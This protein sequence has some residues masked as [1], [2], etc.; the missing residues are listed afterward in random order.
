MIT[1]RSCILLLGVLAAGLGNGASADSPAKP[2]IVHFI[3]D[4]LGYYE[5]SCM[6]HPD[7]RTPN[8][9]KLAGDGIRFTQMLA[10][11]SVCAPTRC[12]LMTGKHMGHA[13]VRG[14]DGS[15]PLLPGEETIAT[16]LKRAGYA[17]GGFGKWGIGARGT[18]GVPEQHGFDVFF[19][20][21]DQTHAHTYYPRYLIRNS[22]EVP[23]PGNTGDPKVGQT[24]SQYPIFNESKAFIRANKDRPFYLYLPWTPPH[25]HWGMPEDDPSFALYKDRAWPEDGRIYAAMVHMVD[26]QLGE[27]RALLDEL[28]LADNTLILFTGD[29]GGSPYFKTKEHAQGLFGP[30]VDPKTGTAFRG[31]KRSLYEGGLRVAAIACWPGHIQPGRVSNHPCYFPD[32]LPTF[33]ELVEAKAPEGIDGI[34]LLPEL[35]GREQPQHRYL[36]WELGTQTAIRM[37]QWKAYRGS[38]KQPWELYDLSSDISEA[39]NVA[40][41]NP[42]LLD[43]MMTF[44]AEARTPPVS[45]EIHDREL[46]GKD[47]DYL[48]KR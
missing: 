19:G 46:A 12:A 30:N 2:N 42:T 1:L 33:A 43:R 24:F 34:S 41:Q 31:G 4:E 36:Y 25:G 48:P 8:I 44:A 7:L 22:A 32:I 11:S 9:D 28:G 20:Y 47:R 18:S 27:I 37:G 6:G 5:L 26:R 29:N 15:S 16:V 38:T 40:A 14:N 3:I 45:G 17:T 10:G 13:S 23:L 35:L 39:K 21:Y